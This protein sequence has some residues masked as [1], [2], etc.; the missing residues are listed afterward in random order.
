MKSKN[1]EWLGGRF[2]LPDFVEAG[3]RDVILWLEMPTGV[4][5]SAMLVTGEV[6]FA[7]TFSDATMNPM[8]GIARKPS[9]IRVASETL[10]KELRKVAG[11]IPISVGPLPELDA[12]FEDF[13]A[14]L[15]EQDDEEEEASYLASADAQTIRD[16]FE[17]AA[18]FHRVAPWQ[19]VFDMHLL[20]VDIPKYNIDGGVLTIIGSAG[21]STG[22]LLFTSM[23]D[24]IA[25]NEQEPREPQLEP[26]L[27][28]LSY[29]EPDML[30]E[31]MRAEIEEHKWPVVDPNAVPTYFVVDADREP[32]DPD[33]RDVNVLTATTR[34]FLAF[35]A[36]HRDIFSDDNPA[37]VQFSA[38]D[39]RDVTVTITAPFV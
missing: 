21:E 39:D 32:L 25:F 8:H 29:V 17:T 27:R 22:L 19:F 33:E 7:E 14:I 2:A 24:F 10:A 1:L 38:T 15:G 5:V 20:R 4:V 30:S 3:A 26:I 13:V 16:F 11:E 12:A 6:A 28:S 36:K 37:V 9:R 23:E 35:F 18:A 34:A 31:L